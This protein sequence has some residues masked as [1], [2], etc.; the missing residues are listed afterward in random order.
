M[1]ELSSLK[2]LCRSVH[3][4]VSVAAFQGCTRI[5]LF[6]YAT[7]AAQI[8]LQLKNEQRLQEYRRTEKFSW[9]TV[10]LIMSLTLIFNLP[11][12]TTLM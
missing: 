3:W 10:L 4:V 11:F 9:T 1:P 6:S 5:P 2:A 12:L 7:Q 8:T